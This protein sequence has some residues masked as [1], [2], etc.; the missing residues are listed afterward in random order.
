MKKTLKIVAIIFIIA[1]IVIQFIR[2]SKNIGEEIAANQI[3]AVQQVPD[4][5]Q[6]ILKV[7]CNDC[8]SNTTYYPWYSKI[9]PAAWFLDDHIV[10]G[11]KEL[12]FSEFA[13]YP[14]YRRYKKFKEIGK[15]VKGGDMPMNSYTLLHRDASLNAD[16]KLLIE[17]WASS[18]MKEMEGKYPADSLV[19]PK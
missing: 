16:Q 1:F 11:K 7:S 9:Q 3:T 2:P 15:E 4:D 8:H 14:T 19:K 13:N 6:Q 17:N 12:N 5:V 18:A 10:E